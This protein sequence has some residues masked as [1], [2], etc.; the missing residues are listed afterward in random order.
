MAKKFH[1]LRWLFGGGLVTVI[2]VV[3]I[4][5]LVVNASLGTIV[6]KA[7]T[8]F[9]PK[10]TGTDV[11]VEKVRLSLLRGDLKVTNLVIGNPEGYNTPSILEIGELHVKMEP[12]TVF[13]DVIHVKL[14]DIQSP[15]VT[16]EV[17]LG[18]SNVST[19][20][21]QLSG[22]EK[23]EEEAAKEESKAEDEA[24]GGK[25]VVIDQVNVV[26]GSIHLAAKITGGHALPVPL[27]TITLKDLGKTKEE[28]QAEKAAA[29]EA[30]PPKAEGTSVVAATCE[31]LKSIFSS[32]AKAVA[33][34]ASDAAGAVVDGAKN[35]AGAAVDGVKNLFGGDK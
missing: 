13:K 12:L 28:K 2:V 9:G 25:R 4:V 15:Q 10:L 6:R 31:V 20:L 23:A 29:E 11:Q 27:P 26:D 33:S 18:N 35:A 32:T 30:A 17:G 16:Y 24:G 14:V 3:V 22:A 1:L 34:S 5:L 8:T 21:D 7:V 19:L